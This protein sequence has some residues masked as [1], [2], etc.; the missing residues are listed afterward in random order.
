MT[1]SPPSRTVV[2]VVAIVVVAAAVVVGLV[3]LG[4]PSEE[5]SRRFD[6]RRVED[7]RRIADNVDLYL[8]REGTLPTSLEAL[9][10]SPLPPIRI[11]D[12]ARGTLY[13]YA[14]TG[15]TTFELCGQFDAERSR[16]RPNEFWAHPA[17]RYCFELDGQEFRR[18]PRR[19]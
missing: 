6:E 17:G 15:D 2:G 8:T 13:E 10:A 11:T 19:P 5:R 3:R 12:P 1:S 9:R 14:A 4:S 7:L 18:R 16:R